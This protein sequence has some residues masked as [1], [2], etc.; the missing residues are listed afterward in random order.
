[1]MEPMK[2]G[3]REV[4]MPAA[5]LVDLLGGAGEGN[6]ARLRE[7]GRSAGRLLAER[8]LSP[9]DDARAA[10]ALPASLFWK[11]VGE[12]FSSR[13]WGTLA[14]GT[15]SA[16]VAELRTTDW[17]EAERS[18]RS[19]R[20]SFTVGLIQG[21]LEAVSGSRLEVEE[22]ECRTTGGSAC[23]F[24]FGSAAALA[25]LRGSEHAAEPAAPSARP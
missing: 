3:R 14:H 19:G 15:V 6:D 11:R 4:T 23:R 25:A 1:M 5:T 12:L 20:C 21:L 24:L 7:Y 9:Q 10:R 18:P 22:F 13:G 8:L 16:G 2:A 17:V